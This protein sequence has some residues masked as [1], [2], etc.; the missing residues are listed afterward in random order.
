MLRKINK[1]LPDT[2]NKIILLPGYVVHN[3]DPAGMRRDPEPVVDP[4]PDN[5]HNLFPAG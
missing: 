3:Q 4:V 5:P 1:C 2:L